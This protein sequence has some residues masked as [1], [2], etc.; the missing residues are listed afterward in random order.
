MYEELVAFVDSHA[1]VEFDGYVL[2]QD[3]AIIE[4]LLDHC[5]ISIP[6]NNRFFVSII[7]LR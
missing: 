2:E 7:V 5:E 1:Q 6:E 4:Y 3:C